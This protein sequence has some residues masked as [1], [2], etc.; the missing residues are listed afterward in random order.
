MSMPRRPLS[1]VAVS[2]ALCLG[3]PACSSS[4][5]PGSGAGGAAPSAEAES[6]AF[7]FTT[8]PGEET[9]WC[10]YTRLPEGKGSGVSVTGYTWSWENMH[11]WALYRTT[12]DLPKDVKLDQPFDCFQPDAMKYAEPA[13]LVLAGG[14]T[15][16]QLFP[17]GT[18]FA[19]KS[20]E[21]VIVQAH[22]VNTSSSDVTAKLSM[23]LNVA[24]PASVPMPLGLIQFYDPYIVV[25]ALSPAKAAM[26]CAIPQDMTILF[27]TTHEHTRGTG[28]QV[29]LDPAGG[30][31]AEKPFLESTSWEHPTVLASPME[32]KKGA[33]IR[34]SCD[35]LGDKNDVFQGQN[36]VNS[37]M[38]MF[39]G[40]YYPALDPK[41]DGPAFE[42]CIQEPIPGG[43]GDEFGTG[44]KT[45]AESLTCIQSCP[46]GDAPRPGDG[47]IDVGE[48]WQR[49][50]V[51]S[52]APASAKL[53][54][55]G[56]CV[57]QKCAAECSGGDCASC[58]VSKCGSEY[59]GCQSQGC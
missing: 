44:T 52:C 26:R 5:D 2:L 50:L 24:D 19:F 1:P 13:S 43:V 28:V 46:P 27:G 20:S 16:E 39:I 21:V 47:R 8:P 3:L 40:Y 51:D 33:H 35:Y 42:N 17:E 23:T 49:C 30:A 54:A 56:F 12:A 14:A 38:C 18:G 6:Y 15:G 36:K 57:G 31:R 11:H 34:T 55:L 29:F 4:T 58:V 10:Q 25:P 41:A 9:H 7:S 48:C 59:S 32:V 53:N 22:T 37:E 45:C